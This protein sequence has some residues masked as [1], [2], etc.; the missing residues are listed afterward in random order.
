VS[1]EKNVAQAL[2]SIL[3]CVK[4]FC[5]NSEFGFLCKLLAECV[6]LAYAGD[7]ELVLGPGAVLDDAISLAILK[8]SIPSLLFFAQCST[9]AQIQTR[10]CFLC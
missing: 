8:I 3:V 10:G 5:C 1:I 9:F 2:F 7:T 6:Q 4:L